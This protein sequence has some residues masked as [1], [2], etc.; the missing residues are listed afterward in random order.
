[1]ASEENVTDWGRSV[2][3]RKRTRVGKP[4]SEPSTASCSRCREKKIKCDAANPACHG[5][6]K[7]GSPCVIIDSATKKT[8]TRSQIVEL[9][10]QICALEQRLKSR[11]VDFDQPLLAEKRSAVAGERPLVRATDKR[12]PGNIP[13]FIGDE[14]GTGFIQYILHAIRRGWK[15]TPFTQQGPE[16]LFGPAIADHP[17]HPLPSASDGANL[18]AG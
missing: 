4:S 5:C 2:G 1:M 3:P 11:G 14:S 13:R 15:N 16:A 18:V 12:S 17:A 8:Y 9:E 6:L 7:A 10:H